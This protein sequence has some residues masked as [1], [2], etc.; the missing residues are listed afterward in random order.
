LS[1]RSDFKLSYQLWLFLDGLKLLHLLGL[2]LD[3]VLDVGRFLALVRVS[4]NRLY[5]KKKFIK[6][7]ERWYLVGAVLVEV[8]GD[9]VRDW[10][11]LQ[12]RLDVFQFR[13]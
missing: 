2:A 3:E 13:V 6:F 10:F 4:Q 12:R 7:V 5:E 11:C 8:F 9:L 1:Y